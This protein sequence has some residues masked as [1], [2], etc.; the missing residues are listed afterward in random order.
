MILMSS[1]RSNRTRKKHRNIEKIRFGPIEL[2]R[3]NSIEFDS[4]RFDSIFQESSRV[5][6]YYIPTKKRTTNWSRLGF[7]IESR[8][9]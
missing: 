8:Q 1:V 3:T 7:L 9:F 2:I 5:L 6:L 4:V